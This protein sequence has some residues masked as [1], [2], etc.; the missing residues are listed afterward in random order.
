[1]EVQKQQPQINDSTNQLTES[2]MYPVFN[3]ARSSKVRFMI[4]RVRF[5]LSTVLLVSVLS[6]TDL[7]ARGPPDVWPSLATIFLTSTKEMLRSAFTCCTRFSCF[8]F[9]QSFD[10]ALWGPSQFT[11]CSG[12]VH[13]VLSCSGWATV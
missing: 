4:I 12:F 10:M 3:A 6:H 7:E 9:G 2:V 5:C 8:H 11:Q 1:M 13:I